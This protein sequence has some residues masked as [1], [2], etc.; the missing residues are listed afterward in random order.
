MIL[1]DRDIL[2]R[3]GMITPFVAQQ[4]REINGKP[5]IS[6]G[7]S[8]AGYD[9]RLGN[10]FKRIVTSREPLDPKEPSRVFWNIWREDTP[11][12]LYPGCFLL[13]VSV[14]RW[15]IPADVIGVVLGKS[16][17]ARAGIL[18]NCTPMEPGWEGHL[19]LEIVNLAPCPVLIYPGEGIAQV[20]FCRA[21]RPAAVS[22]AD[23]Q[24]KYQGQGN[25]PRLGEV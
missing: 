4:V 19:T 15:N 9:M 3:P 14:E 2:E 1:N 18:I 13:A 23:R 12:E 16:T 10:E 5:V 8:S 7:L 6:Y 24:G 11:V 17:Y 22:Y 21:E 20:V 25:V